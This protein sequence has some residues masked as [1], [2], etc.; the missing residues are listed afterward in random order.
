V[1][2]TTGALDSPAGQV[3]DDPAK[4]DDALRSALAPEGTPA[5]KVAVGK[6]NATPDG[7]ALPPSVGYVDWQGYSDGANLAAITD[8]S[9]RTIGYWGHELGWLDLSVVASPG[10]DYQSARAAKRA[11]NRAQAERQLGT[12][13]APR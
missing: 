1:A 7:K 8:R 11:E 10:F 9:G 4:Y 5:G 12:I 3:F 6:I 13:P 2:P